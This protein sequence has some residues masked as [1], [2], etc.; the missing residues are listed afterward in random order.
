[1]VSGRVPLASRDLPTQHRG[2]V[3]LFDGRLWG[4]G[5]M[6]A[7]LVLFEG[8]GR[9]LELTHDPLVVRR[10]ID[11]AAVASLY[12]QLRDESSERLSRE[13]ERVWAELFGQTFPNLERL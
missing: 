4:K 13:S 1:M 8:L 12:L 7:A 10:R 5:E 11:R 9:R 6:Y 2:H 3:A